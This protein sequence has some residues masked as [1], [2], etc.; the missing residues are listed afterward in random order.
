MCTMVMEYC[1]RNILWKQLT[2]TTILPSDCSSF[3]DCLN[4]VVVETMWELEGRMLCKD[5]LDLDVITIK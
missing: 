3:S 4:H 1:L 5:G 2:V